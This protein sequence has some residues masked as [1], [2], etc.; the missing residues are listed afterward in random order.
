MPRLEHERLVLAHVH[1]RQRP[2]RA[3]VQQ[4]HLAAGHGSGGGAPQGGAVAA[5]AF[6]LRAL[7][8]PGVAPLDLG[9]GSGG[10]LG[11]DALRRRLALC[12]SSL[13]RHA[14]RL[15]AR[16]K[17]GLLRASTAK[18]VGARVS[19][20]ALSIAAA[21]RA[22]TQCQ[23]KHRPRLCTSQPLGAVLLRPLLTARSGAVSTHSSLLMGPS[24]GST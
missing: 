21:G 18:R 4:R 15:L 23:L 9:H 8:P 7:L 17:G 13:G 6:A 24:T 2:R 5:K 20:G 16:Q 12:S 19:R 10:A 1:S 14:L 11:V 22:A 3:V